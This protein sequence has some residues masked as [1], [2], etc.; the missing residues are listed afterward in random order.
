M[1]INSYSFK[2]MSRKNGKISLI[3]KKKNII[4]FWGGGGGWGGV[5]ASIRK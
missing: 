3:F 4:F 2:D 5:E 1:T